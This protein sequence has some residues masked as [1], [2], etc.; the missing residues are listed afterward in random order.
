[1]VSRFAYITGA[2]A[3]I[4]SVSPMLAATAE[5]GSPTSSIRARSLS[6]F[7]RPQANRYRFNKR[8]IERNNKGTVVRVLRNANYR[9]IDK[10]LRPHKGSIGRNI[11][12]RQTKRAQRRSRGIR[13]TVTR[14]SMERTR[15]SRSTT[16]QRVQE[17]PP[18]CSLSSHMRRTRCEYKKRRGEI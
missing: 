3:I 18:D 5:A 14:R 10:T 16:P 11:L 12:R 1:M 17:L 8:G 13:G 6:T 9:K 2:L 7:V 4:L 15:R